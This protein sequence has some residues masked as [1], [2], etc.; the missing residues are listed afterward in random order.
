MN[1]FDS[2]MS[3]ST[4]TVVHFN[5]KEVGNLCL[6]LRARSHTIY[7]AQVDFYLS[8]CQI[9]ADMCFYDGK[10]LLMEQP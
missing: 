6:S 9:R 3:N 4:I 7:A 10:V 5:G 2:D 8:T 1:Y